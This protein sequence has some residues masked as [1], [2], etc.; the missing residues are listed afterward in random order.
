[1]KDYPTIHKL[2]SLLKNKGLKL[3]KE[4]T[5]KFWMELDYVLVSIKNEAHTITIVV[6]DEYRDTEL[7]NPII[8]LNLMIYEFQDYVETSDYLEWCNQKGLAP[9]STEVR[10]HYFNLRERLNDFQDMTDSVKPI[11]NFE[12]QLNSEE[13]QVL[14]E[15]KY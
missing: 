6:D 15:D 4:R 3:K 2:Q 7:N 10:T 11:S 5:D 12:W 1:L 14:R 8:L 9:E 13:A